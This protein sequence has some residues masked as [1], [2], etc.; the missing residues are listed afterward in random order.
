M[1][2]A[3]CN[4]SRP[5]CPALRKPK[6]FPLMR[7][8]AVRMTGQILYMQLVNDRIDGSLKRRLVIILPMLR[9]GAL[10]IDNSRPISIYS[11][12]SSIRI[13]CFIPVLP[14]FY[15]IRIEPPLV[16]SFCDQY[17]GALNITLH[18]KRLCRLLL[19]PSLVEYNFRLRSCRCPQPELTLLRRI[20]YT[21]VITVIIE[22]FIKSLI[23]DGYPSCYCEVT[24]IDDYVM[25]SLY[26]QSIHSNHEI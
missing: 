24:I 22:Q 25:L 19:F 8:A 13:G 12:G 17:P 9:I 5:S 15:A 11:Y 7:N 3:C 6:K 14:D 26:R 23:E 10:Q 1:I 20:R 4:I 2:H 16:I 18:S 21:Q